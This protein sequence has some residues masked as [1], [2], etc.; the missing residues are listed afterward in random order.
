M[1][2]GIVEQKG[3]IPTFKNFLSMYKARATDEPGNKKEKWKYKSRYKLCSQSQ[4]QYLYEVT[5]SLNIVKLTVTVGKEDIKQLGRSY[6]K[7]FWSMSLDKRI[8]VLF[9]SSI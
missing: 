1:C 9:F 5:F 8:K 7:L 4:G 3:T 6:E 2:L